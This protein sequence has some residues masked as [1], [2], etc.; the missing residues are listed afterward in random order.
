L[1]F[2][3]SNSLR[4]GDDVVAI[5]YPGLLDGEPT[6]TR[7]VVSAVARSLGTI[8]GGVQTDAPINSGNSGGPL[9]DRY[10]KVV[11]VN[12]LT[13]TTEQSISFS[14]SAKVAER[15]ASDLRLHGAARRVDLGTY[16][17]VPIDEAGAIL[18]TINDFP[19]SAG[20]LLIGVAQNSPMYGQLRGCDIIDRV[21]GELVRSPGDFD[22]ARLWAKPGEAMTIEFTRYPADKCREPSTCAG[23]WTGLSAFGTGCPMDPLRRVEGNR[24]KGSKEQSEIDAEATRI[25]DAQRVEGEARRVTVVPR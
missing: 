14:V 2:G 23:L 25:L 11:A 9:L 10:G 24:I 16:D 5:G 15:V 1:T 17:L 21:N 3:D 7:G 19:F 22:N 18:S 8:G 4:T 20:M 12:T 6:L 13:S